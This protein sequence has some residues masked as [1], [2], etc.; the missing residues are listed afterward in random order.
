MTEKP[1]HPR[2]CSPTDAGS[3]DDPSIRRQFRQ[4]RPVGQPVLEQVRYCNINEKFEAGFRTV[5]T[6]LPGHLLQL[7][8]EGAAT[9]EITGRFYRIEPGSFVWYHENEMV[10]VEVIDAPWRF[11]SMNFIAPSLT[12]PPFEERVRKVGPAVADR[13]QYLVDAWRDGDAHPSVRELRVQAAVLLL[14]AE[15]WTIP[16][17]AFSTDPV[18]QLWWELEIQV[19]EDLS[20]PWDVSRLVEI[21][22]RSPATINRACH[23]ALSIAPMKRI[24]SIRMSLARGLVRQSQ[25]NISEIADRV[26]YPRVHEFSRDYRKRFNTTPS[27]DRLQWRSAHEL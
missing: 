7:T 1:A 19:R 20:Q 12:P 23:A 24:K 4:H 3:D 2:D 6:S 15:V 17:V 10:D 13:F 18:A 11:F 27:D 5:A 25:L 9:H 26:G 22:G 8:I 21:S 14:L 16:G